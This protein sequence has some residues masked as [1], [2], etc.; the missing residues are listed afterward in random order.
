MITW[1]NRLSPLRLIGY[2]FGRDVPPSADAFSYR[3]MLYDLYDQYYANIIY[4]PNA[5][6]GSREAINR[7]LGRANSA[8]DLAG[9]YN[10]VS[11]IVDLYQHVLGGEFGTT[12]TIETDNPR[13]IERRSE[14][15]RT[16][17]S[18]IERIW[19]WSNMDQAKQL[20][21]RTAAKTGNCGLRI[22]AIPDTDPRRRRVYIKPEH[23]RIIRDLDT[24][25]RGNITQILFRY[26]TVAGL[27]DDQT[28]VTIE[29][30][31]TKLRFARW[32]V[33]HGQ[34]ATTPFEDYPNELGVVPYVLLAHEPTGGDWGQNAFYRSMGQIDR[35]NKLV[36]HINTQ[37]EDHVRVNWLMAIAGKPPEKVTLDGTSIVYVNTAGGG[38]APVVEPMVAPLNLADAIT[39]VRDLYGQVVEKQP[40][41]KAIL[42][43]FLSNQSGETVKELR[44]PAEDKLGLARVNYE[45]ALTRA[46][47]IALSYG[48]LHSIW[49][50]GTGMGNVESAERA[51]HEGFEDHGFNRRSLL[52]VDQYVEQ[53]AFL[54]A[55]KLGVDAGMTFAATAEY[56]GKDATWIAQMTGGTNDST[57][58]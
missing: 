50:I 58:V 14:Q 2:L 39:E 20:L 24:D 30:I 19:R 44:K 15:G 38:S 46:Q 6:G 26:E 40:E 56:L 29:E 17:P 48:V 22:V 3:T 28:V 57:E 54:S 8:A 37:I 18:P 7:S 53:S 35:I 27:G 47:Q 31:Q 52:P 12:I 43:Q 16:L 51:Y 32:R 9:Y 4:A 25:N 34:R 11:E 41:L 33:E 55:L 49:D 21:C 45:D 13:L 36:T 10:P 23:P 42:G 5:E 1:S